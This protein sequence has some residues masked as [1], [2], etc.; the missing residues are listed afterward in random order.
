MLHIAL[1]FSDGAYC[2]DTSINR[3]HLTVPNTLL[4]YI[5]TPEIRTPH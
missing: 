3:T 5:T 4:V 1:K 2:S